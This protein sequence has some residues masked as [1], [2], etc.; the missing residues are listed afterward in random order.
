M[1]VA[2]LLK[3]S[4]S[5]ARVAGAK[6]RLGLRQHLPCGGKPV[7]LGHGARLDVAPNGVM[8][9]GRGTYVDDCCRLQVSARA[10]MT[11]GEGCYLNT[12]CRLGAAEDVRLGARTMLGPNVCVFDHG[13][14]FDAGRVHG[15]VAS[16]PVTIGER[17]WPGANALVAKGVSTADRI[18]VGGSSSRAPWR[19]WG[20]TWGRLRAWRG[21]PLARAV[22]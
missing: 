12:N 13:H 8:E 3:W 2:K 19:S 10:H 14:V 22:A 9:L 1:Q 7:Y 15:A 11:I 21:A 6:I 5:T 18:C 16:A 4:A 20:C 17:C